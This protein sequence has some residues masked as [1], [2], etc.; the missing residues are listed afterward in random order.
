MFQGE[1]I[2]I[3]VATEAVGDMM[4]TDQV[5]AIA[6]TGLAGDR[7]AELK[8]TF[9]KGTIERKQQ[10]TLIET[11]A[12]EAAAKRYEIAVTHESS[13]RNLL[14]RGV[15]LNHLVDVE[16]WVGDVKLRGVKLCEPCAHLEKVSGAGLHEALLHRGW[17]RAEILTNGSLRVGDV[18]RDVA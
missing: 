3:R 9:Q 17:L 8:G 14:T 13:R 4:S 12:I 15:P 16:F 2:G 5:E 11:E 18:I 10:V 7:Y 6:G 1:L